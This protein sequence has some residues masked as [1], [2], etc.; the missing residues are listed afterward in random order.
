MARHTRRR[1]V[2]RSRRRR[3]QR[4]AGAHYVAA[5]LEFELPGR[6]PQTLSEEEIEEIKKN[7]GDYF[8]AAKVPFTYYGVQNDYHIFT[9]LRS[10][11]AYF[12][13]SGGAADPTA[14]IY[15]DIELTLDSPDGEILTT[16]EQLSSS[17]LSNLKTKIRYMIKDSVQNLI[18]K[19][20]FNNMHVFVS[21]PN[22]V[23]GRQ[24]L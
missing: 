4:G 17:D 9:T 5:S 18:Y 11:S 2:R 22:V 12:N 16:P 7:I 24:L 3:I 6:Y 15:V 23:H 21:D 14:G 1:R 8:F 10:R 13:L 19:G 20:L